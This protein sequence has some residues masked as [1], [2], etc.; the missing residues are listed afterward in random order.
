MIDVI[1]KLWGYSF[2]KYN[3]SLPETQFA[4]L[5][6]KCWSQASG[7]IGVLIEGFNE[8]PASVIDKARIAKCVEEKLKICSIV[9]CRGFTQRSSKVYH[10]YKSFGINNFIYWWSKYFNVYF[11]IKSL[12][13]TLSV[14]F[15][16]KYG[17]NLLN[18]KFDD[19]KIG[20]LLYDTLIRYNASEYTVGKLKYKKH[21]RHIFRTFY[22]A[23]LYKKLFKKYVVKAVISSHLVYVEYGILCRMAHKRGIDIFLKDMNFFKKYD[24]TISINEHILRVKKYEFLEALDNET[25]IKASDAYLDL[26]VSGSINDLNANKAYFGKKIFKKEE[27]LKIYG[28]SN[29]NKNIFV[30]AH[31]FSDAPHIGENLFFDDYY[32]WLVKTL[33]IT[34]EIKGINVFLKPHPCSYMWHEIGMVRNILLDL[35]LKN[36]FLLPDDFNTICLKDIADCI[37]TARGTAGLE[38]SCFGIPVITAGYGWYDN[39]GI[40]IDSQSIGEYKKNL[41]NVAKLDKLSNEQMRKAKILLYL[42]LGRLAR[43]PILPKQ[44]IMPGDDFEFIY[45]QQYQEVVEKLESGVA[46]MQDEIYSYY[47]SHL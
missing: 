6:R 34:S 24:Q 28:L 44:D 40:S 33:K 9:I 2:N 32:C 25:I 11:L 29:K 26:R 14:F 42:S 15:K 20:D 23:E 45:R 19:V 21:F 39:F 13:K 37:I 30:L 31:A 46:E 1:K 3:A 5:N 35:S 27:L 12:I 41:Q 8:S 17:K 43:S 47:S 22:S 36:V 10:I 4:K 38:F 18:L 7:P 16:L